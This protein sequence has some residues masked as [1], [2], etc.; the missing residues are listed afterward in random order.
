VKKKIDTDSFV[1]AVQE[2]RN[3]LDDCM[4][5]LLAAVGALGPVVLFMVKT[6]EACERMD[7]KPARKI[8]RPKFAVKR[9][10]GRPR[11]EK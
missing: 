7:A 6:M 2:A 5:H 4:N 11:K 3:G 9:G 8:R 1:A 10:P